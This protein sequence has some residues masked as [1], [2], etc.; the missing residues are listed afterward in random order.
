MVR[1][2]W[3]LLLCLTSFFATTGCYTK[4][5][6]NFGNGTGAKIWVQRPYTDRQIEIAPDRFQK[7]PHNSGDLVVTTQTNGQFRFP[8]V[9]V[10]ARDLDQ[11]YLEKGGS[12][13]G[14]SYVTLNVKLLTN[15]QLYVLEPGKT[16]GDTSIV[17]PRGYPKIGLK[18]Y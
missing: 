11:R 1:K 5:S 7:F 8:D 13:F 12:L 9:S 15:M 6:V 3:I 4:L 16:A 17:Q 2:R 14:P 10:L 18:L